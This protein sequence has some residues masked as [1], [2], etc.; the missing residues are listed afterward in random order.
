MSVY[1]NPGGVSTP[2]ASPQLA[3]MVER[4][5]AA[6]ADEEEHCGAEALTICSADVCDCRRTAR[7]AIAAMR[8][9]TEAMLDAGAD[10]KIRC[11]EDEERGDLTPS[12]ITVPDAV[13]GSM[14]DAALAEV[15]P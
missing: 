1:D 7:A 14:I 11:D 9:P 12:R 10:A 4:V 5:A 6:I 2:T 15:A 3:N 8:E 13:W